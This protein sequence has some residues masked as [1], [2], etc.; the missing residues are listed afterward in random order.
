MT[1]FRPPLYSNIFDTRFK[2]KNFEVYEDF[3]FYRKWLAQLRVTVK[4]ILFDIQ[5]YFHTIKSKTHVR[6]MLKQ[7][8][9]ISHS[10]IEH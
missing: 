5:N 7:W 9:H 8:A 6:N 3:L 1:T 4:H 10:S 2:S